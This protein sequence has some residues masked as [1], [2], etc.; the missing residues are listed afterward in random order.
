MSELEKINYE[1]ILGNIKKR[2]LNAK[3]EWDTY[4]ERR[5]KPPSFTSSFGK[6]Y[7]A[8][9]FETLNQTDILNLMRAWDGKGLIVISGVNGCGKT[10]AMACYERKFWEDE[11][12]RCFK[13][14]PPREHEFS[15]DFL[16]NIFFVIKAPELLE[17]FIKS[18]DNTLE[19]LIKNRPIMVLDDM[20]TE[21]LTDY[22]LTKLHWTIDTRYANDKALLITTHLSAPKFLERYKEARGFLDRLREWGVFFESKESSFRNSKSY[23]KAVV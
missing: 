13:T 8:C 20:G 16:Q 7:D 14:W 18:Q 12:V 9:A 3:Q 6:R 22:A 15:K 21:N 17:R 2:A 5:P 23:L 11:V 19:T 1:E 10:A 4:P